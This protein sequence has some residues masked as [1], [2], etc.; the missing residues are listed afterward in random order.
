MF[1]LAEFYK[2]D[3]EYEKINSDPANTFTV[4]HNFM[5]TW[6]HDEYKRLLG[7]KEDPDFNKTAPTI[8]EEYSSPGGKDWR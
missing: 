1:R 6:T 7:A 4:G 2:K 5:S 3:I 8:L